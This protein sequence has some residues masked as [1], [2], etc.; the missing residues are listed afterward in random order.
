MLAGVHARYTM[1]SMGQRAQPA[2]PQL[3]DKWREAD[4]A[5]R[6]AERDVVTASLDALDGKGTPPS[7]QDG[8]RARQLRAQADAVLHVA[9]ASLRTAAERPGTGDG[10]RPGTAGGERPA[11]RP[12]I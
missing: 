2:A 4:A 12:P 5:A 3:F 7:T 10:E 11:P 6:A 9:L 1:P 8:E